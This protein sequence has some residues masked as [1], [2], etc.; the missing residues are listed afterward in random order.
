MQQ[1]R[2]KVQML[3]NQRGFTNPSLR[4]ARFEAHLEQELLIEWSSGT[5]G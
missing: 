2:R 3:V 4:T 5:P 1:A